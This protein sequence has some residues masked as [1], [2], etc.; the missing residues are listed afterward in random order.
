MAE[1]RPEFRRTLNKRAIRNLAIFLLIVALVIVFVSGVLSITHLWNTILLRP[2]LNLLIL[3]SKYLLDSFGLAIIVL[4]V[5]IR[6]I[7]LPLNL[8]QLRSARSMRDLQPQIQELRKKYAKDKQKLGE[9]TMKLYKGRS[10]SFL[11]CLIPMVIQLPI[12]IALYQSVAQALAASNENLFGL[13]KNLYSGSAIQGVLPLSHHFLGL[14]L[15]RGNIIMAILVAGS[16]WAIGRL[17][18]QASADPTQE[19][20]INLMQWILP[21]LFGLMAITLPAGLSLYWVT[22]NVIGLVVQSRITGWD[23]LKMPLLGL[24]RR[25]APQPVDDPAA[26]I[27]RSTRRGKK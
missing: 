11:G 19:T 13:S 20:M 16:M 22:S 4:T 12:W 27:Q 5:L 17:S 15:L 24:L 18:S 25:G 6:L 10:V 9:E 7:A 23:N 21:L 8:R 14:D 2:V 3:L 26:K 1:A